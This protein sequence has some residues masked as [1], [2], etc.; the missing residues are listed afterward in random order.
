RFNSIKEFCAWAKPDTFIARYYECFDSNEINKYIKIN[1]RTVVTFCVPLIAIA[2]VIVW[3][4]FGAIIKGTAGVVL[5]IVFSFIAVG[6]VFF[7]YKQSK[8]K[9]KMDLYKK[10]SAARWGVTIK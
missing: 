9:I 10:V 4:L 2:L 8:N 6:V 7:L 5:G 1:N 3:I